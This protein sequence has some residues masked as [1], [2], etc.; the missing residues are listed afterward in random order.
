MKNSFSDTDF[1]NWV[2]A[3]FLNSTIRK[4][5]ITVWRSGIQNSTVNQE[6]L[7][8]NLVSTGGECSVYNPSL[9][10]PLE[11]SN[12]TWSTSA[13]WEPSFHG[14]YF[15]FFDGDNYCEGQV[16]V[17]VN[18]T[19]VCN[20]YSTIYKSFDFECPFSVYSAAYPNPAGNELIIDREEK[21]SEITTSAAIGEQ[22]VKANTAT[23][24]V[25]LYSHSTAKLVYS[26][27]FS[28]SAEQIRIDTSKLPNGVYYLNMISNN[29]KIKEQTI[30]INH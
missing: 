26:N 11:G 21:G 18:F 22:K 12:F 6:I 4:N 10:I 3:S 8:G 25:L 19:D 28:A 17:A 2:E 23:V 9:G 27:D 14:Y 29:E 20:G 24:K 5:N 16:Y 1:G 30:I 15:T 7:Q 13:G